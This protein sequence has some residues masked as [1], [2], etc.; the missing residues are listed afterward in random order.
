M[1]F[2]K[3]QHTYFNK[4]VDIYSANPTYESG[5]NEMAWHDIVRRDDNETSDYDN[6]TV[7][8]YLIWPRFNSLDGSNCV[9]SWIYLSSPAP[10][11][12]SLSESFEWI[13]IPRNVNKSLNIAWENT[14]EFQH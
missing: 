7:C 4:S 11:L 8:S 6:H 14:N 3:A 10:E 5:F 13:W 2:N 9:L 1:R 12:F